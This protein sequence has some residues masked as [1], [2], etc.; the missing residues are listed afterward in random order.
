MLARQ[1]LREGEWG[2]QGRSLAVLLIL[3]AKMKIMRECGIFV[4]E[5]PADIGETMVN[6]LKK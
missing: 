4:V 2:M 5:S 3:L 1:P 6:A